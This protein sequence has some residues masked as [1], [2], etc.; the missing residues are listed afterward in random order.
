MFWTSMVKVSCYMCQAV[1][2]STFL[3][4]LTSPFWYQIGKDLSDFS[5]PNLGTTSFILS[6]SPSKFSLLPTSHVILHI[7]LHAY[8]L[9]C[10]ICI[11]SRKAKPMSILFLSV[12]PALFTQLLTHSRHSI[13][14]QS[15]IYSMT[16]QL[17]G[18]QR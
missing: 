13:C 11:T 12:Y 5:D 16:S 7:Y 17:M 1:Q 10:L 4:S 18:L 6:I 8:L 3:N 2:Q 14:H 9:T 15:L